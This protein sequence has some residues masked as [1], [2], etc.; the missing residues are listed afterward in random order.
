M[1]FGEVCRFKVRSLEPLSNTVDG[2]RYHDGVFV[3]IDRRTGQYMI[4]S[5]GEMK[6]ARTVTRVPGDEKWNKNMLSQVNHTPYDLHVP[7]EVEVVFK[8]KV[9]GEGRFVDDFVDKIMVSR[10]LYLREVDFDEFGMT[11]GC[12]KCDHFRRTASWTSSGKPHSEACR[13]RITGE[14]MKTAVGRARVGAASNRLDK[15]VEQLGQQFRTDVPMGENVPNVMEQHHPESAPPQFIPI[16]AEATAHRGGD[17]KIDDESREVPPSPDEPGVG[18]TREM[19]SEDEPYVVPLCPE[20][21]EIPGMEVDS[22]EQSD[23][24][25]RK[26]MAVMKDREA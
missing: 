14:L 22:I 12:P 9:E 1:E 6:M 19:R 11:R 5:E 24:E 2:R 10:K 3:G 17:A 16:A 15:T 7:K 8:E 21:Q 20:G 13:A 25:L 26:I 23:D 18:E 4:Y